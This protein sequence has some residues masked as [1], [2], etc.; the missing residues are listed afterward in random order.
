MG[1]EK[2]VK[3]IYSLLE[4]I[5]SNNGRTIIEQEA[6]NKRNFLQGNTKEAGSRWEEGKRRLRGEI[7][8]GEFNE[9]YIT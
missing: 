1:I 5:G 6:M 3:S 2:R 9:N 7:S 4:P 8:C